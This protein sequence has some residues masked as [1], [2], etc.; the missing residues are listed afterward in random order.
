MPIPERLLNFLEAKHSHHKIIHHRDTYTAQEMAEATHISGRDVAKVVI[1][2][3]GRRHHMVVLPAN[4]RIDLERLSEALDIPNA[5]LATEKE[6]G[7]LFPDCELGAMPVCGNLYGLPVHMDSCLIP[8]PTITFAAGSHHQSIQMST[9]DF[10]RDV[11][12]Q[13]VEVAVPA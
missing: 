5:R 7:R 11:R 9:S 8:E 6:L 4:T 1:I 13:I 3:D 10:M 12:P 2:T